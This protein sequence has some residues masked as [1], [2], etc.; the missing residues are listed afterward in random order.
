MHYFALLNIIYEIMKLLKDELKKEK[1]D[2]V[3]MELVRWLDH[4]MNDSFTTVD[5]FITEL[6]VLFK[7]HNIS[8]RK[9]KKF[10]DLC[11]E[12][13]LHAIDRCLRVTVTI[14]LLCV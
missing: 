14:S 2:G 8:K 4:E 12:V 1:L 9:G 11:H 10:L 6:E 13:V 3:A 7:D 5:E